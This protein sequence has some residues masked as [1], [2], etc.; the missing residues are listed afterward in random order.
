MSFNIF[1][2]VEIYSGLFLMLFVLELAESG[3][4]KTSYLNEMYVLKNDKSEFVLK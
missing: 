4:R 1:Y 3:G 2:T